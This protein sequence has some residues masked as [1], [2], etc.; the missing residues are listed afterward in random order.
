MEQDLLTLPEHLRSPLVFGW[1]RVAY[2]LVFFVVL[3]EL[4]FVFMSFSFLPMALSVLSLT[5]P[6]VSLVPLL[7]SCNIQI[8]INEM[9]ES[10]K[11]KTERYQCLD[12]FPAIHVLSK[13][14]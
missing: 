9:R 2:F 1:V 10:P 8:Q 4:L 5:V 3:C 14:E 7:S 11:I 12:G 6:L 13:K